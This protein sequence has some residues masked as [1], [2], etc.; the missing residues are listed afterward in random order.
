MNPNIFNGDILQSHILPGLQQK[1]RHAEMYYIEVTECHV[2]HELGP[3][4]VPEQKD[5]GSVA[6]ENRVLDGDSLDVAVGRAEIEAL[7]RHAIVVAAD[8]T[9]GDEDILRVARVYSVVVL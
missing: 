6:P 8:K 2:A 9:I 1:G 3:A 5:T 7:E 4:L